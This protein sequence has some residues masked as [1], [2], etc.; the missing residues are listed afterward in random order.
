MAFMLIRGRKLSAVSRNFHG[1]TP[2]A[3][4][5]KKTAWHII[6]ASL[7]Y[8]ITVCIIAP[9]KVLRYGMPVFPFFAILPVILTDFTGN[10]A[11]KV[12]A[13][14]I[15]ILFGSFAFNAARE[16]NIENVFRSKRDRYAFAKNKETPVYVFNGV[17]SSWKYGNLIPYVNDGQAYYFIDWS[18]S[19]EGYFKSGQ[20]IKNVNLPDAEKYGEIFILTEYNPDFSRLD[21]LILDNL[22]V[23][24]EPV[25]YTEESNFEIYTGEPETWYPYFTGRKLLLRE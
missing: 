2:Y 3:P 6:A 8:L 24:G 5:V 22:T 13:C 19:F 4:A 12:K 18:K 11:N 17:W 23:Q 14:A 25:K 20:K 1:N 10:K 16:K 21:G 9:Y 15:I 7:I